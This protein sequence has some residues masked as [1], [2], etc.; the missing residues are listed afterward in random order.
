MYPPLGRAKTSGNVFI[1]SLQNNSLYYLPLLALYHLQCSL[2]RSCLIFGV[3]SRYFVVCKLYT[4][5]LYREGPISYCILSCI[6][7]LM[8]SLLLRASLLSVFLIVKKT[9]FTQTW[10]M[11]YMSKPNHQYYIIFSIK[12]NNRKELP[13]RILL[14]SADRVFFYIQLNI[15][16]I[17]TFI[18]CLFLLISLGQIKANIFLGSLNHFDMNLYIL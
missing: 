16:G 12:I 15:G 2:N 4:I 6:Q 5:F 1:T 7:F 10:Y 18:L 11:F 17:M 13:R 14:V 9:I 8:I 3:F